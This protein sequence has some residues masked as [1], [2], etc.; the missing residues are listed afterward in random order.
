[1]RDTTS[2]ALIALPFLSR[3]SRRSVS[4]TDRLFSEM[5]L[6]RS[7]KPIIARSRAPLTVV[8]PDLTEFGLI[9]SMPA[10]RLMITR[11]LSCF[12]NTVFREY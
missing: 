8:A 5:S 11:A 12:T 1:M 6:L 4:S 3:N 10:S 7:E 9:T 2:L